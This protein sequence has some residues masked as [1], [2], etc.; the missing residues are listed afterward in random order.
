MWISN[1]RWE[2]LEERLSN[3]EKAVRVPLVSDGSQQH[4]SV[5]FIVYLLMEKLKLHFRLT[6]A[7]QE[8]VEKGGPEKSS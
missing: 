1:D 4:S 8:L 2:R 6:P 3:V 7:K 5:G